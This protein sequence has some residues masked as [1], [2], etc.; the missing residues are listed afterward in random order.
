MWGQAILVFSTVSLHLILS[1]ITHVLTNN[2]GVCSA[3][4]G[5][6]LIHKTAGDSRQ[7]THSSSDVSEKPLTLKNVLRVLQ[8]KVSNEWEYIGIELDIEDGQLEHIKSNCHGDSKACLCEMLRT[9]L[10]RVNPP[11]SWSKMVEALEMAGRED[12]ALQIKTVYMHY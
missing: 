10:K 1:C 9:W 4:L 3:E 6:V 7:L 11:P 8:T 5:L 12:V 2:L